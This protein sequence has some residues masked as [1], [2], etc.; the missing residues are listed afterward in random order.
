MPA[1]IFPLDDRPRTPPKLRLGRVF[2]SATDDE[3][4]PGTDDEEKRGL[5]FGESNG[6]RK[7]SPVDRLA[8][9][10]SIPTSCVSCDGSPAR[11]SV[12][13]KTPQRPVLMF[14]CSLEA[15][16]PVSRILFYA[17]ISLGTY[18]AIIALLTRYGLFGLHPPRL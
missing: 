6:G 13:G 16:I 4:V 10:G 14:Q 3:P 5:R 11:A 17:T 15:I 8:P 9:A 1:G 7:Q 12:P 2:H 18:Q